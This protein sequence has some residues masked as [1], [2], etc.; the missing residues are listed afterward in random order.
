MRGPIGFMRNAMKKFDIDVAQ[1]TPQGI[2][3][4]FAE[5]GYLLIYTRSKIQRITR[6]DL[7]DNIQAP[8][9]MI[10]YVLG[11]SSSLLGKKVCIYLDHIGVSHAPIENPDYMVERATQKFINH[12]ISHTVLSEK[13]DEYET[14]SDDLI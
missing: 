5:S 10:V 8:Q 12:V 2:L 4:W 1:Y 11:E 14:P 9:H 6:L 7:G 3:D 13:L